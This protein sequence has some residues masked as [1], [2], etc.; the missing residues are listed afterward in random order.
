MNSL[1]YRTCGLYMHLDKLQFP[2]GLGAEI[3]TYPLRKKVGRANQ[4]CTHTH[5]KAQCY[6][7]L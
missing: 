4:L 7:L 5:C 1:A 3:Q 2:R 6:P